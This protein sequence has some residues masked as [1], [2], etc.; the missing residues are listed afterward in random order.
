MPTPIHRGFAS[1]RAI[2]DGALVLAARLGTAAFFWRSGQTKVNGFELSSSA[3]YLFKEEYKVP[4]LSPETAAWAAVTAEHLFPALL[5][6]GLA[7]RLSALGLLAMTAV[8]QVFVYPGGWPDHLTWAAA[9]L[10]IAARGPGWLA[11]DTGLGC[12]FKAW[13]IRP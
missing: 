6:A 1:L 8:I 12:A 5:V 3:L 7:T 10:L 13:K 2:P 11:L 4:L 9:L